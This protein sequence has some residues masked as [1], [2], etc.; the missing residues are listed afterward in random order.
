MELGTIE[1][2][3]QKTYS[4]TAS[5]STAY[6]G[7]T[8]TFIITRDGSDQASSVYVNTEI[9]MQVLVLISNI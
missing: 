4:Y 6:E 2:V 1:D 5:D 9:M 7:S 3:A 8:A